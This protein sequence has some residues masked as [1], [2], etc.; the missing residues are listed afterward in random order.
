MSV[1]E[2]FKPNGFV[3]YMKDLIVSGAVAYDNLTI[4]GT[5]NAVSASTG[6]L[7]C[8]GGAGIKRDMYVGGSVYG[9]LVSSLGSTFGSTYPAPLL[10]VADSSAPTT[11][12]HFS[13]NPVGTVLEY[14]RQFHVTNS[15]ASSDC[16]TGALVINGGAGIVSNLNVGGNLSVTGS[17]T[18]QTIEYENTSVIQSTA[19]AS[20]TSTGSLQVLGGV[21]IAKKLFV[22]D[23][24]HCLAT[25]NA[26]NITTGA[27]VITGG[28]AFGN[29]V[30]IGGTLYGGHISGGF[31]P[32]VPLHLTST[33]I[34]SSTSTGALI[35]DGG[36][37]FAGSL[38]LGANLNVS[39]SSTSNSV[40]TDGINSY[41]SITVHSSHV[42]LR[43]ATIGVD[44]G[45]DIV[46]YSTSAYHSSFTN[47]GDEFLRY[48]A[49]GATYTT[50]PQKTTI[51]NTTLS[52]STNSGALVVAGGIGCGDGIYATSLHS[53]TILNNSLLYGSSSNGLVDNSTKY[54]IDNSDANA[55]KIKVVS[56][57]GTKLTQIATDQVYDISQIYSTAATTEIW[58]NAQKCI[59]TNDAGT[60]IYSTTAATS[61]SSGAL[62]I[63]GGA[64]IAGSL[65]VD[66]SIHVNNGNYLGK[67]V[68]DASWWRLYR[69][70]QHANDHIYLTSI[71]KV[72]NV[73]D[74]GKSEFYTA[75]TFGADLNTRYSKN[76]T[77]NTRYC[78]FNVGGL[79]SAYLEVST[80]I[81]FYNTYQLSTNWQS[82]TALSGYKFLRFSVKFNC[83]TSSV[84]TY[85]FRIYD[86]QGTGGTLL[87]TITLAG[88]QAI[89][90]PEVIS[91]NLTT[92]ITMIAGQRYTIWVHP[93]SQSVPFS[94]YWCTGVYGSYPD[95][96][97]DNSGPPYMFTVTTLVTY[98]DVYAQ[99]AISDIKVNSSG[100]LYTPTSGGSGTWP[101]D[102][103][104]GSGLVFDSSTT[105]AN[106]LN[107][108]GALT[109]WNTT[110]A[111]NS[112]TGALIVA[113]GAGISGVVNVGNQINIKS[114]TFPQLNVKY[115]DINYSYLNTNSAGELTIHNSGS[116][117]VVNK[118][119]IAYETTN[120]S[121]TN[122][123]SLQV[124][125][126]AGISGDVQ[127]GGTVI[128]TTG[129][130]DDAMMFASLTGGTASF[131]DFDSDFKCWRFTNGNDNWLYFQVEMPHRMKIGANITP[132][133][134]WSKSDASTGNIIWMCQLNLLQ[135]GAAPSIKTASTKT[136][137]GNGIGT[138]VM[139]STDFDALSSVGWTHPVIFHGRIQRQGGSD[140]YNQNVWLHGCGI[141]F[142]ADKLGT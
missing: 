110:A 44:E 76:G 71:N 6:A 13:V 115:D 106:S 138:E 32:S 121:S 34:A 137:V 2:L 54:I 96:V 15:T 17:I 82:F 31:D 68:T 52:T 5:T 64:G 77:S 104:G 59:S 33:A 79:L 75:A 88:Y 25:T 129:V 134:H 10:S 119:L 91:I 120:S 53:T 118:T 62:T 56:P 105:K 45:N 100:S 92:P 47:N 89:T 12:G 139:I 142:F 46:T 50:L 22:G 140:T 14:D 21:G 70:A 94:S 85:E 80:D 113:G 111:T 11:Y 42:G 102:Y 27:L 41:G 103:G 132:H 55:S 128:L 107:E 49:S 9:S 28:A 99:G 63:L 26:S 122:S 141:H 90:Q 133:I 40:T 130:T 69:M 108:M 3:C 97:N 58:G 23:E 86:G 67:K 124:R 81:P 126:G 131:Q 61:A 125:G 65:Y 60:V 98:L 66:K 114:S 24:I 16:T 19:D 117:V 39:G 74:L 101:S 135:N 18:C 87:D 7:I 112:V 127:I 123:G 48:D 30:Y 4:N 109:L 73:Y 35:V 8:N 84:N 38:F 57:N 95:G 1:G 20:S 136:V 93:T 36:A 72:D 43:T 29:D 37:G 116:S 83:N 51:T 78:T